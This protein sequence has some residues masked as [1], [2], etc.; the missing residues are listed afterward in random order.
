MELWVARMLW[1]VELS[2]AALMN[3]YGANGGGA[4]GGVNTS[5]PTDP[6]PWTSDQ[7]VSTTLPHEVA[8]G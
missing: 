6:N 2:T 8:G 5:L 3:F 1:V 7:G 4:P